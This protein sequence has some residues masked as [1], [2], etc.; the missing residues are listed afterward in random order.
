MKKHISS[1]VILILPFVFTYII[2][3]CEGPEGPAGPAGPAGTKG[4]PGVPCTVDDNGDGTFTMTCEGSAP[5]TFGETEKPSVFINADVARGGQLYDKYWVVTGGNAPTGDHALYPSFGLKSG[6]DTWRCKECHGWDYIGKDGQYAGGSH[7]TGIKGLYPANESLW[8]AF[9]IIKDDHGYGSAGLTDA[10]IWDLV[11]FYREGLIDINTILQKDG[12]FNG[13]VSSGQTLYNSGIPGFNSNG[14]ANNSSCSICHN[15]DGTN[16]VVT[17]FVNFP[18]F[19][20]NDNPQEFQHKIRFGHPGSS[21]AMPATETINGS[22]GDV[23]DLSAYS[24]TLSPILWSTTSVSRGAQ[25]YDN[26]WM[27]TGGA[28]PS[29]DHVLY[30]SGGSITGSNTWRCKECHGWDYIGKNGRYGS[31]SHYTGIVGLYP[32]TKTKWQAF[33]EIKNNHGYGG[34]ELTDAD[35]WDLV[36]FYD[37]GMYDV[38]FILNANGTFKGDTTTGQ[39]L[40]V[41]GIGGG[42][43]CS[44]CHGTDG[45]TAVVPGFTDFP[46]FLSNDNP[47]EFAH[48]VLYGQP[49]TMMVITYDNG[50]TLQDVADLSVW[51]QTLPQN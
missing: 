35:I 42:S 2:V 9:L 38:N 25:L 32:T 20:S 14:T 15:A 48:K 49:G 41:N 24:Q 39:T 22:L 36:A 43:S 28:A 4:D 12:T 23:A 45:L 11:K 6:S 33:R 47:Q 17:G 1:C 10:D 40:F 29:G 21:P 26:Y 30:P 37:A 3:S 31:G 16:A 50:A 27:V 44:L 5:V 51:A 13:D 46:G 18:G 19:L 34:G 8:R 7:Y